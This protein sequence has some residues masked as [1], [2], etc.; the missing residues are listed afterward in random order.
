MK[1]RAL[2]NKIL[3]CEMEKGERKT[4]GG[5]VLV[6]DDKKVEGIR[7]RWA[8]VYS[9]SQE[10][11]DPDVAPGKWILIEH[12]RW[13]RAMYIEE[14]GEQLTL[15]GVEY[16]QSILATSDTCPVEYAGRFA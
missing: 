3:V 7:P 5:I 2:R 14:D 11:K 8:K 10:I 12:A 16:P 6:D 1:V 4:A 9:V 15:W 13:T